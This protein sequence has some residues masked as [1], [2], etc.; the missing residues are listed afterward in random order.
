MTS[1]F[2]LIAAAILAVA[3]CNRATAE[4][5]KPDI[6]RG[7]E[8]ESF[9]RIEI[10]GPYEVNVRT[11][12][13]PS[14]R[15]SG[16]PSLIEHMR[17]GVEGGVLKIRPGKRVAGFDPG[18]GGRA[19]VVVTTA[20][21]KRAAIAGSGDLEVDK[22]RGKSFEAEVAGSGNLKIGRIDARSVKLAI[23][24]SGNAMLAGKAHKVVYSIAGSGDVDAGRLLAE[25]ADISIAG[26]GNVVGASSGT[27]AVSIAGSGDVTISGGA[28]CTVSRVGSGKVRC[29]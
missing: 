9:D 8:V 11:G 12:E 19:S 14:V 25:A 29:S 10:S 13:Q 24:G 7:F 26:S 4:S 15:A 3:S 16:S 18:S 22:I 17:V 28:R 1:I 27:A 23:A 6:S 20:M 5:G 2:I 21:L